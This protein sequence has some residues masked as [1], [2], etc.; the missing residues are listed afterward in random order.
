M[1]FAYVIQSE[2]DETFFYKGHCEDLEKRLKQHNSGQ[3]VSIKNKVPFKLV[4]FE[5]F[6]LRIQAIKREKYFKSAAGRKYLK[7]KISTFL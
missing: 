7:S 2:S 1:F 3:T 6:E 5:A 4:Y